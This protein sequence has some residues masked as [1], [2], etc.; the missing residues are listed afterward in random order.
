[1][2]DKALTIIAEAVQQYL[3]RLPD[4][5]LANQKAIQPSH[6]VKPDGTLA[7]P[8]NTLGLALVNV[9]E[10]RVTRAQQG[11]TTM[12]NG[13]VA[14]LNPEVKLNLFILIAANFKDYK[15]GLEFLSGAVR[16]FQS[17]NVFTQQNTPTLAPGIAKLVVE[18]Q[19][20]NF[21]Q[22]NNLWGTLGGKYL[23]SVLYKVRLLAIQE[24]LAMDDQPAITT[25]SL[26]G[27]GV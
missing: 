9:E 12:A 11:I 16:F 22:Q 21:E 18:L 17:C 13:R 6:I 2:I 5:N 27:R 26:N 24:G 14:H 25:I 3:V 19:S 1:M 4:L 23:P 10:E 20:L 15:T 8:E 7:I